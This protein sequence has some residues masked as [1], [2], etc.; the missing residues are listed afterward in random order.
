[1]TA[2]R[3]VRDRAKQLATEIDRHNHRY[4]VLDDPEISDA[5]YDR[6]L[7]ELQEIEDEY[8]SLK[9][10]GSPTQRV[11]AAPLDAF[12][13][14]E[15][16][17]P[18]LS[19]NNAFSEEEVTA[20]D[21]RIRKM[22]DVDSVEYVA[23]PK[24]D[25]LAV[26]LTYENGRLVRGATRGDGRTGEDITPN[27]RTIRSVPLTLRGRG[28]PGHIEV[29][30]EVFLGHEGFRRLNEAQRQAGDKVFV[31]PRN[32]AAGSLRQ[33]DSSLT[34]SRPLEIF[35]YGVGRVEGGGIPGTQ[36]EMLARLKKWG[37]RVSP[38]LKKVGDVKGCLKYYESMQD[39]RLDLPYDIDGVVYKVNDKAYQERLGTVSRA[40]RW[41]LAHKFPAQE[42]AT[43]VLDIQVQ[44]G[45][46][47]AV[48]PVARLKPVFV[49]GAT[50]S[51]ATLHNR[52]EIERL[53]VRKGDTVVV[54][55]AGDVIPEVVSVQKD[56]R[57]KGTRPYRFPERCPVCDSEIVYEG[58]EGIVARCSGGLFCNAQRKESIKHFASRRAMDVDGLGDK[59]VEQLVDREMVKDAADLYA[60]SEADVAGLE[61]MADKSAR[62]LVE[63]LEKSRDTS[64]GRFLFALGIPQ[65]GETTARQLADHFGAL[66]RLMQAEPERLQEVP[67]I[68]P[69]VA[70][71]IHTF[72]AQ[73]HNREVI[74]KLRDAGVH[75]PEHEPAATPD[76]EQP[77]AGRSFVLTGTLDSMTRDEAKQALQALGAKVTG[78]VSKKTDYVV[79]GAEPGSKADR[80]EELGVECLDEEAFRN[81]LQET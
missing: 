39:E 14:V 19:L 72:F 77:L 18:M 13:T 44:V 55:R 76:G 27:I 67:D 26:S 52:A 33:L 61:R 38:L 81:L 10:P 78:S 63:A 74:R 49:G 73:D 34:A 65:V 71:S 29:R 16:G 30:G 3:K 11:G 60:L 24:L 37:L 12:D 42:E 47:G 41:A 9:T 79:V 1:M 58:G 20:F 48:T 53:D 46:T 22:L 68:G 69:I 75:W 62:N 5:E 56:K 23:E 59:L 80:A 36:Y 43:E 45:R 21:Q 8:P 31:N 4:Y 66:E 7:R 51:N 17:A 28:H 40:P 25:G 64:L 2:P 50:V 70:E 15:H 54:R 6:L 35:F 32:A 57:P